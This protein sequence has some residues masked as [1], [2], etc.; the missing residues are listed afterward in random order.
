MIQHNFFHSFYIRVRFSIYYF[1]SAAVM[2]K[3]LAGQTA[4]LKA[5]VRALPDCGFSEQ[6]K[7]IALPAFYN[8]I[9]GLTEFISPVNS[10]KYLICTRHNY[11][12]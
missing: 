5:R 2:V 11:P 4:V 6:C 9:T 12:P 10:I 8:G 7:V 1:Y 3:W